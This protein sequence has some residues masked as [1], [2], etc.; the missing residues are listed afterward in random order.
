MYLGEAEGIELEV[1]GVA[2]ALDGLEEG[3]AAEDL[4]EGGPQKDLGHATRLDKH[5]V[6]LDRGKLQ[7]YR[8]QHEPG[9]TFAAKDIS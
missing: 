7:V 9:V 6:G 4:E 3:D 2:L 1:T 5:V 8:D